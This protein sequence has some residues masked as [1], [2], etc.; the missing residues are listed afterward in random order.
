[1]MENTYHFHELRSHF[2]L[3]TNF[4]A[5]NVPCDLDKLELLRVVREW[6]ICRDEAAIDSDGDRENF[7][8]NIIV[9]LSFRA[10]YRFLK[11]SGLHSLSRL[12]VIVVVVV[13]VVTSTFGP[14]SH[15]RRQPGSC[16]TI[17][18]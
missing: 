2:Q 9:V 1:M 15:S 10:T 5:G 13:V 3:E 8:R 16:M 12:R 18:N 11:L 6:C 17:N 4:F 7:L 14:N